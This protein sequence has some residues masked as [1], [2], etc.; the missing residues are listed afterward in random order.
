V[1][2]YLVLFGCVGLIAGMV[3]LGNSLITLLVVM[4]YDQCVYKRLLPCDT[5]R[6]NNDSGRE[7]GG[8]T[9]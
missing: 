4:I 3:G 6:G 8:L 7:H 1:Y 9:A 2:G 5:G